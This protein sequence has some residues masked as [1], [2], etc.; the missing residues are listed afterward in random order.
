MFDMRPFFGAPYERTRMQR[1]SD[2]NR[3]NERHLPYMR[4]HPGMYSTAY[5]NAVFAKLFQRTSYSVKNAAEYPRTEVDGKQLSGKSA[6]F[7]ASDAVRIFIDLN[8]DLVSPDPDNLPKKM[9]VSDIRDFEHSYG[10]V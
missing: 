2:S 10:S 3:G 4:Q 1:I 6:F 8:V 7:A 5:K 9:R